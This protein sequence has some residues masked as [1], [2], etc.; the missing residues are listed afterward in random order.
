MRQIYLFAYR[1]KYSQSLFNNALEYST[2]EA[3]TWINSFFHFN[4]VFFTLTLYFFEVIL[5]SNVFN[6]VNTLMFE[7]F[8]SKDI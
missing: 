4:D 7:T 5:I 6:D 1:V 3:I 2:H 8:V